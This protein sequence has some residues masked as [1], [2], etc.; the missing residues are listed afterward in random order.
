MKESKVILLLMAVL[1]AFP[2]DS[3][4]QQDSTF[5]MTALGPEAFE[6]MRHFFA[7]DP[8][9]PLEARVID[10]IEEAEYV[11]EKI[12]FRG[13]RNSRVPG[14][15]ALPSHGT[16][17][18][19]CV[20]LLHGIGSSKDDWWEEDSFASGGQL[21]QSLLASGVAVLALDAEY[22][23]ERLMNN[24]FES[25][26]VFTFQKGWIQRARDM[27]V[28]STIEYRRAIDYLDTRTE[29]DT[30]SIGVIGYSMGGMMTFHLTAVDPR[31]KAAVASVTP[32]LKEP[33]SALAVHNFASAIHRPAFLMLM[34][35]EDEQ[36][37]TPEEAQQLYTLVNSDAKELVFY[38]SGH[39]L[40]TSW[41]RTATE[42]IVEHLR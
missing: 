14:Y 37:Y 35:R 22:H 17:P 8:G 41:T 19:P 2:I 11:R 29:I 25:S 40:P 20:L 16:A 7:Y 28:Q 3:R 42:W 6:V 26:M 27:T 15:L 9:V 30:S 1:L 39:Q 13:I 32:I 10:R 33:Y 18:Y 23:G 34:G 21:T 31:I 12:V 24:D 5:S 38:E 36:N 4:A